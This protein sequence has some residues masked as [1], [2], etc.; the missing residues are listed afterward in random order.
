M[1]FVVI[2]GQLFPSRRY[3]TNQVVS[4]TFRWWS[5]PSRTATAVPEIKTFR[6]HEVGQPSVRPAHARK[7]LMQVCP[8]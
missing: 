6:R 3:W 1:V 7:T 5:Q 8:K 4:R 2:S